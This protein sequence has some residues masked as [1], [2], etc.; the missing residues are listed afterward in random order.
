MTTDQRRG[1]LGHRLR[2]AWQALRTRTVTGT[3]GADMARARLMYD[4]FREI[5]ASNDAT[6]HLIAEVDECVAGRAP[7][8]LESL[9]RQIHKAEMAVFVMV[10]NLNLLS[11]DAHAGLYPKLRD[12]SAQIASM[13]PPTEEAEGRPDVQPLEH[14]RLT[15]APLV[16]S[17]MA[18]LGEARQSAGVSVPEGFVVT[19]AAFST[20]M[21]A[22]SLWERAA[23]LED[24][25]QARG[26]GAAV[27]L[28][29]EEVQR[30]IL[31]APVPETLARAITGAFERL[32]HGRDVR[33]AMRSSAVGE[34]TRA[35][36]AGQYL[37]ELDVD[38][39]GLLGAYRAVIASVY[40]RAAIAY[41]F[42]H[43]MGARETAMAVGCLRMLQPRCSGVLFSRRPDQPGADAV[44]VAAVPG[45][46]AALVAGEQDACVWI[47]GED[48][49]TPDSTL[50]SP[51][52]LSRLVDAARR[53]EASL[54]G[55]QEIEWAIEPPDRLLIVQSR[56]LVAAAPESDAGATPLTDMPPRLSGGLCACPGIG[57]GR[58]AVVSGEDDLDAFPDRGVLVARQA[59]PSY[60]RILSKCA[61]VVTDVGSPAGHLASLAREYGVPALVGCGQATSTLRPGTPVTVDATCGRVYDGLLATPPPA[62]RPVL[63][64]DAPAL[65]VL[66]RI[67][68]LVTPLSLTDPASPAFRPEFCQSLHDITRYVH[69]KTFEAVFHWGDV[70]WGDT[71]HAR[72]LQVHLPLTIHVIDVGGGLREEEAANED[73]GDR[74]DGGPGGASPAI[75]LDDVV[76]TPF[77]AL[78]SGMLDSRLRWDRPRPLSARGFLAVVGE[79]MAGLPGEALRVGGASY[80]IVSDRY[81]NFSTKAGYHFATI[82][83]YCGQ[84]V[85][86]NYIHFRFAGGA[87]DGARRER[88]VR[89]IASVLASLDFKVQTRGDLLVARLGQFDHDALLA[90][91]EDMG[92]LCMCTR[93]MDMLMDSDAS[94]EYFARAFLARD[95]D[96]F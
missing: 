30:A 94:P 33:V 63:A 85:N 39:S 54:R 27:A 38:A 7:F 11:N 15:D 29:C 92:R 80:A 86:K 93:Q 44:V 23:R 58:V 76:S 70:N 74:A 19:T 60:S 52:D 81:V 43:G 34:D 82:D 46:A 91:L 32:A 61:A 84:S 90:R 25:V 69:E 66:K 41:R 1:R 51:E 6:L 62:V 68:R 28:A 20:F 48:G 9:V 14:V 53:L 45:L 21:S 78:L 72:Q 89:F 18:R 35:S 95:M 22:N 2:A 16:G 73:E 55:P 87:A 13:C 83:T 24:L 49:R 10:K 67:A 57:S 31:T 42:E 3:T 50:L 56:P 4:R 37:T 26:E 96:R 79:R 65:Q 8:T 64:A 36:H 75:T 17:K 40:S 5:L 77:R 88:R 59:L 71:R 12:L 47:T